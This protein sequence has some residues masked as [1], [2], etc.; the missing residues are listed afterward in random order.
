MFDASENK[1]IYL[2]DEV[3]QALKAKLAQMVAEP[4]EKGGT[5]PETE[6]VTALGE[7]G[8]IWPASVQDD[9]EIAIG[10]LNEE[11]EAA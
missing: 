7:I 4:F 10:T 5:D 6:V 11:R 3:Y 9:A 8:N 2:P 1:S